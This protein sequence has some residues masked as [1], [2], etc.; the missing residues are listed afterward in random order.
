M[1]DTAASIACY[2]WN[3]S[4]FGTKLIACRFSLSSATQTS[5]S[6]HQATPG[7]EQNDKRSSAVTAD[8][9]TASSVRPRLRTS[10]P[11]LRLPPPSSSPT[12]RAVPVTTLATTTVTRARPLTLVTPRR[13][14]RK[15]MARR[16]MT[17]VLRPRTLSSSWP[18]LA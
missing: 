15:M 1:G 14:K 2:A 10:T 4:D 17:P 6:P 7:C 5:T 11:R 18:R 12:R 8:I 13:K 9:V 16:S 3:G